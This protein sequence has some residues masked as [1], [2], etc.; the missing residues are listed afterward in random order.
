MKRL[1]S[2]LLALFS[3]VSFAQGN[4]TVTVSDSLGPLQ[5]VSVFFYNSPAQFYPNGYVNPPV[6]ENFNSRVFTSGNGVAAFSLAGV[7]TNDTV[8]WATQDCAGNLVWGAGSPTA[9]LPNVSGTLSLACAPGDCD[10]IIRIDSLA[11]PIGNFALVEAF[12]LMEFS[13]TSLQGNVPSVFTVNNSIF[14]TGFTSSNW[15]SLTFN[16]NTN[17]GPYNISYYRVDSFC[18]PV[19]ASFG[20]TTGGGG[21]GT[22]VTCSPL[23]FPDSVSQT[24]MGYQT[25][26]INL[27]SSNGTIINYM[28]DFGDGNALSTSGAGN[29]IHTYAQAGTYAVCLTITSVLGA[30]T[31]SATY[32]DSAV[33]INA[34]GGGGGGGGNTPSCQ[35]YYVVDTVNSGLFN[36]QLIIWETSTS[37][38]PITSWSWDFGDGTTINTRYPSHTYATTGVYNVCLTITAIDSGSATGLCT[39]TFCDSVGFDANGNLVYKNG[40]TIN[41]VDPATVGLEE[42]L[43]NESLSL[44]PNPS[45][46]AVNLEWDARLD[47][48]TISIFTISGSLVQ[49]LPLLGNRAEVNGLSAGAYLVKVQSA[50]ATKTLRLIVQ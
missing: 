7:N 35:A 15:D 50:E 14:Q 47:I 42:Q 24:G 26:F 19:T 17:P 28:W 31:C 32:C 33:V 49:E 46:G 44:Y 22:S 9:F 29:P 39:S 4:L 6:I 8:F 40:F 27:S 21:G 5:G 23:F 41:V 25:S 34:S 18:N 13:Q 11:N 12:P 1:L 38:G 2:A 3:F 37:T 10:A 36:N 30:D 16:M 45:Q 43:L 20:G 48:E